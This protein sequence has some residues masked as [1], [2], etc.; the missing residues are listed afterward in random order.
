[1]RRLWRLTV[2]LVGQKNKLNISS[3]VCNSNLHETA[4]YNSI[5]LELKLISPSFDH[6]LS[7]YVAE[8][9]GRQHLT[10][11][12]LSFQ[13]C[14]MS[15]LIADAKTLIDKARVETQVQMLGML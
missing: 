15:G 1:M 14:A 6:K 10:S 9:A 12:S 2:T 13:G 8:C 4:D 7:L 3:W 11:C 5:T